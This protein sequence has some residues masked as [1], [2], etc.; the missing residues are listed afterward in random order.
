MLFHLK[1]GK[2]RCSEGNTLEIET[3]NV[4]KEISRMKVEFGIQIMS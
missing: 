3:L 1:G 4:I 2:G